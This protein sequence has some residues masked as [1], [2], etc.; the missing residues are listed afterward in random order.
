LPTADL[1]TQRD[2]SG[3]RFVRHQAALAEWKPWRLFGLEARDIGIAAATDQLAGVQV[4]RTV[5]N[6]AGTLVSDQHLG[7][8]MFWFVLNGSLTLNSPQLGKVNLLTGD[9]CVLPSGTEF[10]LL[11]QSDLELLEVTLPARF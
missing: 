8:M 4:I 6:Y 9:S 2:F 7:E 3:Q 11:A 5:N 10:S 1:L